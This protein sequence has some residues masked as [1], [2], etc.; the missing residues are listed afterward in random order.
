MCEA[1]LS[2]FYQFCHFKGWVFLKSKRDTKWVHE[3]WGHLRPSLSALWMPCWALRNHGGAAARRL[4]SHWNHQNS[5]WFPA[6]PLL[7]TWCGPNLASTKTWQ[8]TRGCDS[9]TTWFH[10]LKLIQKIHSGPW[11]CRSALSTGAWWR[12]AQ[13]IHALLPNNRLELGGWPWQRKVN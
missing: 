1:G 2:A 10:P 12:T 9:A 8:L 4:C 7:V 6:S 5:S 3:K 13:S 11:W